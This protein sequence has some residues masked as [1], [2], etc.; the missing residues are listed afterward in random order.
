MTPNYFYFILTILLK[1]VQLL[2]MFNLLLIQSFMLFVS[3]LLLD[4]VNV[5]MGRAKM[6]LSNGTKFRNLILPDFFFRF[7]LT[8]MCPFRYVLSKDALCEKSL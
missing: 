4:F 2:L 6:V 5:T 1:K 7:E 3:K 8:R